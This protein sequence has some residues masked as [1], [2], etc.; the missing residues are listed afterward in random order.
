MLEKPPLST[1]RY[2][3]PEYWNGHNKNDSC[4]YEREATPS[5]SE[6]ERIEKISG[7]IL[8]NFLKSLDEYPLRSFNK[9]E[10]F[11]ATQFPE[12][13][14]L[15][16]T[17]EKMY[18]DYSKVLPSRFQKP[19]YR[20]YNYWG[21]ISDYGTSQMKNLI[22]VCYLEFPTIFDSDKI[23]SMEFIN[24]PVKIGDV[25]HRKERNIFGETNQLVRVNGIDIYGFGKRFPAKAKIRIPSLNPHLQY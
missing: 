11:D 4:M 20:T 6:Q 5:I 13:T 21:L 10:V 3:T 23:I 16:V 19:S 22:A 9:G 17:Y 12:G 1:E 15:R 25:S 18:Y 8:N 24:N 2:L 14:I 7:Y